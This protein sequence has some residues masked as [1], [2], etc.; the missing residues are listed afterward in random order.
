VAA[1]R[2]RLSAARLIT[3]PILFFLAAG[4]TIQSIVALADFAHNA[5]TRD[6]A[7]SIEK[8][9]SSDP[10]YIAR[11]A[12]ESDLARP[13]SDCDDAL[14][15][16][17]LTVSLAALEGATKGSDL[18]KMDA[19][20]KNALDVAR[21]RLICNPLDG[22]AWLRYAM[23][24]VQSSGPAPMAIEALRL[25]YWCAPNENWVIE[26]RLPFA[27]RLYLAGATEFEAEYRDDLQRFATYEP[28]AQVAAT[29]VAI[30]PR[31]RA[32]LHPLIAVQ[33]EKRKK[34]IVAEIDRLGLLFDAP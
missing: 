13:S 34:A 20:A 19:A 33:P 12:A 26:A 31:I 4:L 5:D 14:T 3:A 24:N 30:D 21:E 7:A 22:N 11:F 1:P 28:G 8:G 18:A 32:L 16:A 15:R 25:S 2:R 9:F 29:Y 6:L 10:D 23:I 27:T 17:R